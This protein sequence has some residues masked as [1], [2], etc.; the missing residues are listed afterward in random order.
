M[1]LSSDLLLAAVGYP[2][3]CRALVDLTQL[4][5]DQLTSVVFWQ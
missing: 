2:S 5:A 1:V 4:C 3:S